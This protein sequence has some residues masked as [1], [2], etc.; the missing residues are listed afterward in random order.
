MRAEGGKPERNKSERGTSKQTAVS[1][2]P[3]LIALSDPLRAPDPYLLARA[4]PP[5]AWLIW[6]TYGQVQ[7]R[8]DVTRLARLVHA[9]KGQLL[10]AGVNQRTGH[11]ARL[12]DGLHLP[13]HRLKGV[14]TDQF[15]QRPRSGF[16]VTAAAHRERD[17]VAAA[18]AGVDV[19]LISPVFATASHPGG[20]TLGPVR[21]AALAHR[22]TKL[23]L[24]VFALG[25]MTGAAPWRRLRGSTAIGLAGISLF[26][27]P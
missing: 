1:S 8:K 16:Q 13:A 14:H 20:K 11:M 9:R 10:I 4:L 3:R 23:G 27:S 24:K 19:V 2:C 21:F 22:A 6:R 7:S 17:I 5:G 18:R 26:R 15:R 12:S 25:G